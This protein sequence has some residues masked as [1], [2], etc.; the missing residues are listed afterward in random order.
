MKLSTFHQLGLYQSDVSVVGQPH[1]QAGGSPKAARP[2]CAKAFA[3]Q[4][5]A[6]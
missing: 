6:A 3:N 2:E 1:H 4:P 5:E